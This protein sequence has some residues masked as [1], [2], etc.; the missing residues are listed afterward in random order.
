MENMRPKIYSSVSSEEEEEK[1]SIKP[2]LYLSIIRSR[3]L[4]LDQFI[5]S[6]AYSVVPSTR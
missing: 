4:F 5:D 2:N 3:R 1:E 6:T